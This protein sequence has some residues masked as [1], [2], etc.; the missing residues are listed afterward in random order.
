ML[1]SFL[2]VHKLA[3]S[4]HMRRH[5]EQNDRRYPR[6]RENYFHV[7]SVGMRSMIRPSKSVTRRWC[8]RSAY[9]NRGRY[10]HKF[11]D[12]KNYRADEFYSLFRDKTPNGRLR[13]FRSD[14]LF[15]NIMF[16]GFRGGSTRMFGNAKRREKIKNQ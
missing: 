12:T 9:F 6:D 8:P 2:T 4:T 14:E 3:W 11:H 15:H 5:V 7:L 13:V 1:F 16:G 10:L